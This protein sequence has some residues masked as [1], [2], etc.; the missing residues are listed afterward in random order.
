MKHRRCEFVMHQ[1]PEGQISKEYLVFTFLHSPGAS[2]RIHLDCNLLPRGPNRFGL[3]STTV[4]FASRMGRGL[5][6][7][8][9]TILKPRSSVTTESKNQLSYIEHNSKYA[10]CVVA[11]KLTPDHQACQ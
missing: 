1:A 6:S 5:S 8:C 9:V 7:P 11:C 10:L 2:R 4:V 3:V